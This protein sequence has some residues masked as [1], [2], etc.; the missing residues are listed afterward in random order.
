MSD[1]R[2]RAAIIGTG[3]IGSALERDPLRTKPHTHAG[4]YVSHPHILLSG[5][6]DTNADRLRAFGADWG[7]PAESL[8]AAYPDLLTT[9]APDLVSICAYAPDR[10]AMA[11]DALDAG[12]RGLWLEKAV[13]TSVVSAR[14][15]RAAALAAGA[16]V[17]VNHPRSQ[18]PHYRA[19][20]RLIDDG[21]LGPLESIHVLFSGHL[22]HTGTHAWE[23]L[24]SWLGPWAE[25]RCW[26]DRTVAAD[27]TEPS[28]S[29]PQA[30]GA[31]QPPGSGREADDA[32]D[33]GGRVHVRFANGVDA[34]VSGGRKSYFIFQF[35][36]IFAQGR[37]HL[38]NDVNEVLVA[39][40]SPRYSGF[41]ELTEA[42]WRLDGPGGAPLVAVLADAVE[43]GAAD[44]SSLDAAIRALALGIATV[45]AAARPGVPVTPATLD[46]AL[47]VASV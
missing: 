6:A 28:G 33:I 36:L 30:A 35:D 26:P 40:P 37:I 43:R 24:D 32:H 21:T 22:I 5:G 20:R 46:E 25:V 27:G 8:F 23:V 44:L 14:E 2:L 11:L 39:G 45:Q 16:S 1:V 3:R 34:F 47:V 4:W 41:T 38:G 13:A 18:D 9:V 31:S 7:L 15:L 19:V 10:V 29:R 12:A 42:S 17:V